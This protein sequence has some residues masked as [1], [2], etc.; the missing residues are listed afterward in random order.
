MKA[1]YGGFYDAVLR[2]SREI[3]EE[4]GSRLFGGFL[5]LWMAVFMLST[6]TLPVPG[7]YVVDRVERGHW[8]TRE[9]F[10]R[11]ELEN[12]LNKSTGDGRGGN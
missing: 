5:L 2:E 4:T 6:F 10:A 12:N 8:A 9:E 11:R 7:V 1:A 3:V